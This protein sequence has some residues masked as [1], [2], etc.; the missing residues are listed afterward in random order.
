MK[1]KMY[2]AA[3]MFVCVCVFFYGNMLEDIW[4]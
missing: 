3:K 2:F 4:G 1:M